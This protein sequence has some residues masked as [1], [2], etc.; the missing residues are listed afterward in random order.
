MLAESRAHCSSHELWGADSEQLRAADSMASRA[1]CALLIAAATHLYGAGAQ[2]SQCGG[3]EFWNSDL[4]VCVPCASCKQYPK[5]PSCNTCLS[6]D[7]APDV[8]KLA[9]IASFSV[10]AVV[11]VGAALL[12]GVMLHRRKAHK[13][14]LREPIEET[15]GPLYQA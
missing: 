6:V 9:A 12:I 7:E 8:W 4:D 11:L 15:A 3:L 2:R 5:T 1:L 14:P 10:L 13:R